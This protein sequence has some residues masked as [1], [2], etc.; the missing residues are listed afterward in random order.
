MEEV[1][2]RAT[3]AFKSS[4]DIVLLHSESFLL[5]NFYTRLT[6][7]LVSPRFAGDPFS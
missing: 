6:R 3:S 1:I 2:R 7:G 5:D 4:M